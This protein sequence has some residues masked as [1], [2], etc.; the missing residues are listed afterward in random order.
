MQRFFVL[1]CGVFLLI[2][3]WLF[4]QTAGLGDNINKWKAGDFTYLSEA[5]KAQEAALVRHLTDDKHPVLK[6]FSWL[7]LKILQTPFIRKV[8]KGKSGWLFLREEEK[9]RNVVHQSLGFRKYTPLELKRWTLYFKQRE[10]WLKHRKINYVLLFI[11]NKAT[12]YPEY[13]PNHYSKN[14]NTNLDQLLAALPDFEIIDLRDSLKNKKGR[15]Q[16]YL[17]YDTHWNDLGAFYGHQSI[18][19]ALSNKNE[20]SPLNLND[21]SKKIEIKKG[22]DLARLLLLDTELEERQVRLEIQ[23]PQAQLLEARSIALNSGRIP[24]VYL[25]PTAQLPKTLF[26]HDSF[27]KTAIPFLAEHFHESVYLWE[28]Q[29]FDIELIEREK[30]HTV[31]NQFVE[32]ATIGT[33]KRNN[34]W[35]IQEYWKGHFQGLD[36]LTPQWEINLNKI[37]HFDI[38]SGHETDEMLIARLQFKV[39]EADKLVVNYPNETEYYPIWG[40]QNEIFLQVEETGFPSIRLESGQDIKLILQVGK[41]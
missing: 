1:C 28:W 38:F 8:E 18:V 15:G 26:L 12:V 24:K 2:G 35:V 13:L 25:K 29:G 37:A 23:E 16:L 17:T 33:Q 5:S 27:L 9:A 39:K 32:R 11:P 22:G 7:K 20:I 34:W 41:Y 36:K 21:V 10:A 19:K 6:Y 4:F 30:P 14:G 31:V 3:S 40:G